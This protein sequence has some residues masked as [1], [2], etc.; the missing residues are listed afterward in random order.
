MSSEEL[1]KIKKVI[2]NLEYELDSI[3][4][5]SPK[6][7]T[8]R[9]FS[10]YNYQQKIE[11]KRRKC[12][13]PDC[14]N[15]TVL[16]SH[17][18]PKSC[19]LKNIQEDK[20]VLV[21]KHS[22]KTFNQ[23]KML[24]EM[25]PEGI[26]S[27]ATVFPGFCKEHENF[28]ADYEISGEIIDD[29]HYAKQCFR[30][31]CKDIFL[32]ETGKQHL[33]KELK[34][35]KKERNEKVKEYLNTKECFSGNNKITK[36][37]VEVMDRYTS[38][39]CRLIERMDSK[40]IKLNPYRNKLYQISK[41][42]SS[43]EQEGLRYCSFMIDETLPVALSGYTLI[44][45]HENGDLSFFYMNIVPLH[46]K[47]IIY[48]VI[49][50][51]DYEKLS[52]WLERLSNQFFL[53]DAIEEFMI[54]GTNEWCIKPSVWK[55]IPQNRQEFILSEICSNRSF[56]FAGTKLSIFDE[57]RKILIDSA[58]ELVLKNDIDGVENSHLNK[59]IEHESDKL[60]YNPYISLS[61]K[62]EKLQKECEMFFD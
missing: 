6:E 33:E 58:K 14:E 34:E 39:L 4:D 50:N 61:E 30:G 22:V 11:K 12:S 49:E 23:D 29:I 41:K 38:N 32:C 2:D 1:E 8:A 62:E 13:C 19:S 45:L 18:I 31:L 9:M 51:R 44:N 28:F 42:E 17:T 36:L 43:F 3:M 47:S 46:N 56:S 26:I 40:L 60:K 21:P 35:F 7:R 37:D 53:L 57:I 55:A 25:R 54:Y 10:E 5:I 48:F 16:N 52:P 15:E 24:I 27:E 59:W 20:K